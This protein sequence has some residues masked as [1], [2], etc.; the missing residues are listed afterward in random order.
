MSRQRDDE[1]RY[2]REVRDGD[3]LFFFDSGQRDFY[4]AGEIAEEFDLDRSQAHRRLAQ[5][6]RE[7]ELER[8]Q[9]GTR[10]VV[11]WRPR[12]VVALIEEDSGYSI[13]DTETGV[14]SQGETRAEALR[15]LAEAI[16]LHEGDSDVGP[17]EV[18]AELDVD[19]GEIVDDA[20]PPW[21]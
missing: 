6:A 2:E 13:V 18:Y 9:V 10:N 5:L 16:E 21:E 15:M 19:P 7:G 20:T 14:A 12:G 1:G 11:W 8:V 3:L 17:D 4:A